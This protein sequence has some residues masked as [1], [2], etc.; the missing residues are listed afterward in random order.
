MTKNKNLSFKKIKKIY[1]EEVKQEEPVVELKVE[2]PVVPSEPAP[3]IEE[4]EVV[5]EPVEV[6]Q[7]TEDMVNEFLLAIGAQGLVEVVSTPKRSR[8]KAD[9]SAFVDVSKLDDFLN[10]IQEEVAPPSPPPALIVEETPPPVEVTPLTKQVVDLTKPTVSSKKPKI[11]PNLKAINDRLSLFEKR[12]GDLAMRPMGQDPGG[13]ETRLRFLDDVDRSTIGD[14]KYLNYNETTQKFQFSTLSG[15][16]A[17]QV[18]S[19]WTQTDNTELSFI[20]NKPS[21]FSGDYNDLDN[22]PTLFSGSYNDLSDKPTLFSGSYND[23][24]D[25]PTIPAAQIQSDWNQTNN[26][27]LDYIKNKPAFVTDITSVDNTV[28][29]STNS[30]GV[31]DLSVAAS[32]STSVDKVFAYVTNDDSVTIHKGDPVYLYRATGNRPSVILA[33][34][35][36]DAYSAKTLGLASQDIAPGN[37]GWVQTQGVLTG[38]DTKDFSEGDT[39]YLSATAGVLTNVKPY[40]PN[41]LVYMG[42]VVRANQGQGQ[43][44]IKP[45]NGYELDEIHDVDIGHTRAKA[46]GQTIVW[47]NDRLVWENNSYSYNDLSNKPSLFSGAYADL[48]GK[49]TLFSGSYTDLTNKP[50]IPSLTGY[51]TES[52]VTTAISNV[53]GAAPDALNT[54]KEIA[55]Q[56]ASDESAVSSLTT[57][58]SGKVSLTGSYA[59]PDWITSLAYSKLTG[60]PSNLFYINGT[61][62]TLGESKTVTADAT[63]LTGTSLKSTV[64]GSSLTSVGTLTS[65][66]SNGYVQ[67]TRGTGG[68]TYNHSSNTVN[69]TGTLGVSANIFVG[70]NVDIAAGMAYYIDGTAA[71]NGTTL[72][73]NIVNSSLT[74]VG[75]LTSLSSG[76]ITTTGILTVN[77]TGTSNSSIVVGGSN[78]KG[79]TGYHDFLRVTNGAAGA[80]NINKWF[81]LDSSGTLQVLNSAYTAVVLQVTDAGGVSLAGSS[82]T[83]NDPTTNW[84]SFNNNQTAIYD[85]GNTHIHNRAANQSIWINTNGGD[86]RLLQQSPV[87]GGAVGNS[88]IMGG[89][90]SSS[91]TAYLNVLGYK[92]YAIS[93]YG[94]LGTGG[95]G[96]VGGGSGNVNYGIYC[97]NRI[98]SGEVD[99]TSD[100]RA[101][102]IQ[103]TIPLDQALQFVRAV[104]GILYTWKP[105][106][107]DDGIKSGFS[108]QGVHKAGF[109]HMIGHIPNEDL[110][111]DVDDDGWT[112]PDKFQLTMGY[113]QAIP[114]HHEVIKHLLDKVEKLEAMVAKLSADK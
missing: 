89:S 107:G 65:L 2:Q 87:N 35:T 62:I 43:I 90:Q 42:V 79:G 83:N 78:T 29:I 45:Q 86:L 54:L 13:G 31:H 17:V 67:F 10:N 108:A 51:A 88:V 74:S 112:H 102:N 20:K 103:G 114:Y 41:H 32:L 76:A 52:Y 28:Q 55:D 15:G 30:N 1:H 9:A 34:N 56:L 94:Y 68:S 109:D 81:R 69:I 39:L 18:Q 22:L 40:A 111:G 27:A 46:T 50:T 12:L 6:V 61:Q 33:K 36:S 85:D 60:T 59:N 8:V 75:T 104:D 96:T 57:A 64:V 37:P 16:G 92:T 47:N 3:I 106:F 38:V 110:V 82:S 84:L 58:V 77:Y 4:V 66:T 5:Q 101:K 99:V 100:E 93:G 72:G 71:L 11:D 70:N 44:Y 23:L 97:A 80:T 98:Q 25:K 48:T 53:I 95:A 7:G 24:T 49:P 14:G 113:N 63:T 73:N 19:D 26:T 91:A 105:G 21:L